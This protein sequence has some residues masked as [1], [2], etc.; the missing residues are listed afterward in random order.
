MDAVED[1]ERSMRDS[2]SLAGLFQNLV[3]DCK[4]SNSCL[5]IIHHST[6]YTNTGPAAV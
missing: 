2:K 1:Y 4:V 5:L 3:N 6:A